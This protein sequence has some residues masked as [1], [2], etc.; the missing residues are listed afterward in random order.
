MYDTTA[1]L[2]MRGFCGA[3]CRVIFFYHHAFISPSP[4]PHSRST[5]PQ[6]FGGV[7]TFFNKPECNIIIQTEGY[8][9]QPISVVALWRAHI[10]HLCMS[11]C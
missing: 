8:K 10:V 7:Q 2:S 6:F 3:A 11:L 9:S 1:G 4:L 5:T